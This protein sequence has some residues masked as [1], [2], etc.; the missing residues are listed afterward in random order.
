[1]LNI[2]LLLLGSVGALLLVLILW[3]VSGTPSYKKDGDKRTLTSL[4]TQAY[5]F[6]M[7]IKKS[8]MGKKPKTAVMPDLCFVQND[9]EVNQEHVSQYR[10]ICGFDVKKKDV[11][12][13]YPYVMI[14]P[15]QGLL[16]VDRAFPFQAMGLVHLANR[17]QQFGAIKAGSKV[18]ISVRFDKTVVPHTKGY[19]FNVIS[20]IFTSPSP[21]AALL[22]RCEAT[23]LSRARNT[24]LLSGDSPTY[25]SKLTDSDMADLQKDKDWTLRGDF[26]RKYAAI[27]GDYNP[28]HLYAATAKPLGFPHGCIMHGMWSVAACT[29]ALMPDVTTDVKSSKNTAPVPVAEMY[30]E[31]KLPMYL[32]NT[33]ILLQKTV[34]PAHSPEA[35]P[36]KNVRVFELDMKMRKEKNLVPHLKGWC[37]WN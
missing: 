16:L 2:L 6:G 23:Y 18:T 4:P 8:V 22:W 35:T 29:A 32:P 14:F 27:S 13:T 37:A 28:I 17:I 31:M 33:P 20:E 12:V 36:C 24:S 25:A 11:P 7:A 26:S 19:C 10:D 1:M 30:A 34:S 15:I 9:A 5:M 21:D 3:V